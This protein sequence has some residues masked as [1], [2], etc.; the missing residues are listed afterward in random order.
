MFSFKRFKIKENNNYFNFVIFIFLIT[1]SSLNSIE[2]NNI[3]VI[4]SR[5]YRAG[6]FAFN[7]NGD[8]V[9]EYSYQNFR[10]FYGL[11]KNGKGYFKN[12]N[13][14]IETEF[15]E[16]T[17]ADDSNSNKR[18]E[19]RSL[20]ISLENDES[21]NQYYFNIGTDVSITELINLDTGNYITKG[22]NDFLG[23]TVYSYA[24]SLL[25][26]E[27]KKY[28]LIFLSKESNFNCKIEQIS[29]SSFSFDNV[30]KEIKKTLGT[31]LDNRIVNGF[32]FGNKI[33]VFYLNNEYKYY[34][35]SNDFNFSDNSFDTFIDEGDLKQGFGLFF[36]G[37]HIK[38]NY[39]G[40]MYF[41]YYKNTGLNL[42]IGTLISSSFS[43]IF[44]KNFS[45]YGFY[46]EEILNDFIKLNDERLAYIGVEVDSPTN[47]KI[48]LMDLYNN[49]QYLKI[50]VYDLQLSDYKIDRELSLANYNNFLVLSSTVIPKDQGK[51]D[52]EYR[53][54][55]LI[56]F[57]YINGTDETINITKYLKDNYINSENN[58]VTELTKDIN[59]DNNIFGYIV[60]KDQIKLSYIPDEIIFYNQSNNISLTSGDI[61]D[62]NYSFVQNFHLL[63]TNDIYS[64][65]YQ[66]II[67]E[68]DHNF[69]STATT[70]LFL[71]NDS[72]T[73]D[74]E[75]NY[76]QPKIYF[77]RTNT[78]NF[79]L[80]FEFCSTCYELGLKFNEQKCNTC[81]E[82]YNYYYY[83]DSSNCVDQD[84][85]I[86]KEN[87]KREKCIFNNSKYY[88][89]L[90][91]GKKICFKKDYYC[92]PIY[93]YLN[94]STNQCYN[95]VTP[96][97]VIPELK[98]TYN[99]LI[100]KLCSF[101]D[102]NNNTEIYYK[103]INE[104]IQTYPALDGESLVI[105]GKENYVFQLTTMDNEFDSLAGNYINEYNLSMIDLEECE[106]L[107]KI[108]NG[109]ELNLSL[110][111]LKFE[112]LTG[113]AAEKN[114]QYE[115][116]DPINKTKLD[117]SVCQTTSIGLY[118]PISLSEKTQNLYNELKEDGYDLFNINDT[119]YKDICSQFTS[120]NG[121]DVVLSDRINNYYT[122]ETTCQA[123]CQYSEYS[124]ETKY[125][126]CECHVI[127]EE[128]ETVNMKK[129]SGKI[130]LESFYQVLK[131]SNYR[132][133]KCYNL[134]F[135]KNVISENFGSIL[136]II[137]FAFYILFLFLYI[138]KGIS[139]L[140]INAINI[141]KKPNI[142]DNNKIKE[143]K[144]MD[145]K[146][147]NRNIKK[148]KIHNA[149]R[150][151][152]L[153][154]TTI[155]KKINFP[156]KRNNM[157]SKSHIIK[158]KNSEK[159][160]NNENHINRRNSKKFKSKTRIVKDYLK[161]GNNSQTSIKMNNNSINTKRKIFHKKNTINIYNIKSEKKISSKE[162]EKLDD[163]ELNELEYLEAIELDKRPFSQIYW[164]LLKRNQ[165]ILF[166]FF[167]CGDYN[168]N[169]VKYARFI[170][171]VCT[172]MAMN[173]FFFT[174]DSMHKIYLNYGKY[175]FVQ[176]I[177]Q[178]LYSTG[179]SQLLELFLCYL[180]F[181]DKHI[182]QIKKI[183][184]NGLN[185]EEVLKILRCIK[186]KLIGF[187]VFTSVFFAFYWYII[188]CFCT[189]YQNT[190]IIFIKDSISSFLTGLIYPF[191][192][193]LFPA[194]LRVIA[195]NHKQKNLK[196]IYKLSDIIP[197][198]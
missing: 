42:K 4:N 178:I 81:L 43:T 194:I 82:K 166:T 183:N 93:P 196:C 141:L 88:I 70:S 187:F 64:L 193:Y 57:C 144:S 98:C 21:N 20:F 71:S 77:G 125:L 112:K 17:I 75:Q 170:F 102:Y 137:Y 99:E 23:H 130:L 19:S 198:F 31:T 49:Y 86:D 79:K 44:S 3:I 173:V 90:D 118:L 139:S 197:I 96:P 106:T 192:L 24:F 11:K 6:S 175:D 61:L 54:S 143:N 18:F 51:S 117:L 161:L 190:Q 142:D 37:L 172:D 108:E 150:N 53:F 39:I 121:T 177:P 35:Y 115:V 146:Q 184:N 16:I 124:S 100:Q 101:V 182:Y 195:L 114:V 60:I 9:I 180:C 65:D 164:V 95:Y 119:F 145:K 29:F 97:T 92:P 110:I 156:P 33:N 179:L 41:K 135:N 76:Y 160:V 91:T 58:L 132:I 176:Q 66:I 148:Y 151:S 168:I 45:E 69:D 12:N 116:Y 10:L 157:Q 40:L 128:I 73:V 14:N 34:I 131:Y 67:Q 27:S 171:L 59:I 52:D 127:N 26:V 186:L 189:V 13:N 103:I 133:L 147:F 120:E 1:I 25:S 152:K 123:N 78:L 7:S 154:R 155:R 129:F 158:K 56:L 15:K 136:V 22:T 89:D 68:P 5:H 134:I 185:K 122:N 87:N 104:I 47:F 181:T 159:S 111:F 62:K 72:S 163:Y 8:M 36:K 83:N 105:E 74:V 107:L 84:Y 38:D 191:V 50:R 30:T 138:F 55:I 80:C 28:F 140:K 109:L 48:I 167:S 85:F 162:G 46:C 2:L 174:D 32:I 169:Y 113:V 188:A 153:K 94:D 165:L 126:K 149:T 63:K